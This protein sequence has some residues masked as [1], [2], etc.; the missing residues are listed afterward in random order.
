MAAV[1]VK[2]IIIAKEKGA[3]NI[4]AA[5]SADIPVAQNA[6]IFLVIRIC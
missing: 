2:Q 4:N 5:M 3:F 6:P 1:I